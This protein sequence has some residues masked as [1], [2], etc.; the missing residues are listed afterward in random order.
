MSC[1]HNQHQRTMNMQMSYSVIEIFHSKSPVS[2][3]YFRSYKK[4]NNN[5]VIITWYLGT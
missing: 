1:D 5:T 3:K 4:V 2:S